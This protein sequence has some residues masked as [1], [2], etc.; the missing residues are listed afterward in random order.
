MSLESRA[1]NPLDTKRPSTPLPEHVTRPVARPETKHSPEDMADVDTL[2]SFFRLN[3]G[4][5]TSDFPPTETSSKFLAGLTI[6]P[7]FQ[8]KKLELMALLY[9]VPE[10]S[11]S[12]NQK[13]HRPISET[14]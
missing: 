11:K 7:E 5:R 9:R 3:Q 10:L 4:L 8:G 1:E 6:H 14:N 13:L 12:I 2:V